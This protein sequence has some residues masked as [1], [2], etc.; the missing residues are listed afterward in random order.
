MF[1]EKCQRSIIVTMISMTSC[2][3]PV[4]SG[5]TLQ[6]QTSD[7]TSA[8]SC[9]ASSADSYHDIMECP[10]SNSQLQQNNVSQNFSSHVMSVGK[11]VKDDVV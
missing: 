10:A 9:W 6:L 11:R 2:R 7:Q 8:E 1:D 4:T 5:T 3:R